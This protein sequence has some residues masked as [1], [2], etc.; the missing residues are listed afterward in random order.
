MY[1][2]LTFNLLLLNVMEEKLLYNLWL[3]KLLQKIMSLIIGQA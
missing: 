3:L 2:V 1:V